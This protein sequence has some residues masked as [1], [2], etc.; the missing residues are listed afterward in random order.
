MPFFNAGYWARARGDGAQEVLHV[1]A[2]GWRY[3]LL[4]IL[5]RF[6]FRILLQLVCHITVDRLALVERYKIIAVD[7]RFKRTLV[8]IKGCA[9]GVLGVARLT[10][11]AMLPDH[12][13]I[14]RVKGCRLGVWDV[15]FAPLINQNTAVGS[16]ALRPTQTQHPA[17]RIEHVYAH[18]S[19]N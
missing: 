6:I 8:T 14:I 13:Q 18:I 1:S 5:L 9:P 12:R 16:D 19:Q 7:A 4:Q 17:N 2:N 3:V 15:C 11:G 10:P